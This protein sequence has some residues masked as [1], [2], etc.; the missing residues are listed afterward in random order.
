MALIFIFETPPTLIFMIATL[1]LQDIEFLKARGIDPASLDPYRQALVNGFPFIH[2]SANC[3]SG[4]EI[5]QFDLAERD[6][7]R[8]KYK[9][10]T[11]LK[12]LK[13]VPASGAASRMFKD[14]FTFLETGKVTD[15]VEGFFAR[16][17]AYPFYEELEHRW[18]EMYGKPEEQRQSMV[19]L[20]LLSDGMNY[21]ALPKGLIK[22]HRYPDGHSRTAFEEHFHEA[23]LCALSGGEAHIHFTVPDNMRVEVEQHLRDLKN[24]LEVHFGVKFHIETSVQKPS[25]D[26]PAIYTS[27][28]SWVRDENGMLLLR[29]AGHGALLENLNELDADIVFIKNIDNVVPD[30]QKETTVVNKELLAGVL[31]EVQQGIFGFLK[32]LDSGVFDRAACAGFMEKWFSKDIQHL[33]DTELSVILD[34]PLR[35]C[36]MVKNEGEPGGGPFLVREPDGNLSLQIVERS[37]VD[38]SDGTQRD[39]FESASHF[40]P[41]DLVLGM[42]DCTGR[43]FNLLN[44]RNEHTGMVVS[45]NYY[46]RDINALE[47]PGLWNGSMH[48]WNTIFVEVP[49]ETF[50]PVKTIFDLLRPAHLTS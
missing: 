45:K 5:K 7:L 9:Q 33:T 11:G 37:Q 24:C 49:I 22:F 30:S 32:Q 16:L 34:R 46:G 10:Q 47:L 39:L 8:K 27:D 6:S 41:V 19:K 21:G 15:A 43:P 38:L 29:P 17:Y 14:L 25:T 36:G 18:N 12:A 28:H 35:V 48:Y 3:T 20:L 50:N 42:K 31:I 2:L 13:F 23:Y 40:N 1:S 26:T 4:D 44:Y